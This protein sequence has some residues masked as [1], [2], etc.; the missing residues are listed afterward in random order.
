MR[1]EILPVT[2]IGD[3]TPGADLAALVTDA[4]P[5]LADG[6]VLVVT[7]KVV[8]KAEGRLVDVPLNGPDREAARDEVLRAE[9]ARPVAR[10]GHTRIV[11]T[12]HG[13][14]LASA[15]IDASNV[16][17][18]RLVLLPKD[19]DSSARGLRSALRERYGLDVAVVI[20]D[21]MGRPW[22]VGLT[23]LAIGAAGIDALT[24]FRGAV[25]AYGNE[26][27]ITQMAVVDELASA[28]ELVKG[29][30]DQVPVAVVRGF[31]PL[32]ADDGP[33]A[34]E[35]VRR[36]AQ[37]LFSLGT[38]EA[39]ALGRHEAATLAN[40]G[41]FGDAPVDARLVD[42]ALAAVGADFPRYGDG[43]ALLVVAADGSPWAV[44]QAGALV[45]R[46]RAE[47]AAYG[48]V[49]AWRPAEGAP[50][51]ILAIGTPP[52]AAAPGRPG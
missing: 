21:T 30:T 29:K 23:D 32:R 37:D 25:D 1:L 26:L 12:H 41:E 40:A 33:G 2:G 34:A 31:R 35:L 16:D 24:D 43:P 45:H 39:R 47:L 13:F 19:P 3:V 52:D 8:S 22:R 20:T 42:R 11:Q 18:S 5:W 14:V 28:A 4:A 48:L 15:G 50:L 46:L 27:H 10:R 49:T 51:G 44:A 17:R 38:A 6:D 9:T 36:S 7:S